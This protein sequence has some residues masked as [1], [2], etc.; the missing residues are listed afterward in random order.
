MK[1]Q[2]WEESEKRREEERRS[3]KIREGRESEERRC[4]RTKSRNMV[5]LRRFVAPE[6]RH[7][8]LAKAAGAETSGA[9]TSVARSE[10]RSKNATNNPVM[11]HFWHRNVLEVHAAAVVVV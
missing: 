5:F 6:D 7:S 1:K 10:F 4:R 11:H 8:G 9:E 2:R 3:E